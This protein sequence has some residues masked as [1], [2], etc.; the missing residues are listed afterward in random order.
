MI[1]IQ[2][3]SP[4]S[5]KVKQSFWKCDLMLWTEQKIKTEEAVKKKPERGKI[6]KEE[7]EEEEES[8]EEPLWIR[9]EREEQKEGRRRRT[10]RLKG[11]EM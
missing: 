2:N 11:R 3:K 10:R 9:N 4:E 1:H 6:S 5:R 8:R 7:K